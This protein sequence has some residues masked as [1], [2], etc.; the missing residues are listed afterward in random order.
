[1]PPRFAYWT[2]LI[3]DK[4]TAF[5]AAQ[6][7]DLLPTLHQLQRKNANVLLKWFAHG[8]LW[9]SRE[10][11]QAARQ[12]RKAAAQ[13]PGDA[14]PRS[15][16]WRPGGVHRDPRARFQKRRSSVSAGGKPNK[17]GRRG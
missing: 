2:I 8:R 10:Q 1:M 12:W 6:R 15:R 4:P 13:T 5:R 17:R 9:D 14:K 16:E 3:D 11:Q 7:D